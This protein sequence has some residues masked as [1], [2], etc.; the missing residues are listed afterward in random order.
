MLLDAENMV[1]A[2]T[3]PLRSSSV[4]PEV[5]DNLYHIS[6]RFKYKVRRRKGGAYPLSHLY[7]HFGRVRLSRLG[8]DVAWVKA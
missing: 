3:G 2:P 5:C 7:G 8:Y 6:L 1:S 4:V